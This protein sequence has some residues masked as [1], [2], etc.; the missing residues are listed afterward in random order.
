MK[1]LLKIALLAC[2]VFSTTVVAEMAVIVN[3]AN[4]DD[5]PD[6]MIQRIFLGKVKGFPTA[7]KA[8]PLDLPKHVAIRA[9]FLEVVAKKTETQFSAYWAKIMFTGKGTPPKVVDSEQEVVELVASNP[10]LI[11]YVDAS[12]VTANVRVVAKY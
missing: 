6:D 5:I 10:N 9:T 2:V 8:L 11:G 7:G 1:N 4:T 3:K 12:K